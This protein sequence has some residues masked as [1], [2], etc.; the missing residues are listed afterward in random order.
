MPG[1]PVRDPKAPQDAPIRLE[2]QAGGVQNG[3]WRWQ[4]V[5][6]DQRVIVE[7]SNDELR[8]V[9]WRAT[10]NKNHRAGQRGLRAKV[11]DRL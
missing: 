2:T 1:Y 11:K 9:A 7:L 8:T 10:R 3:T 6:D 5:I 4:V